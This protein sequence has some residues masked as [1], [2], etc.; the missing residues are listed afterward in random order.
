MQVTQ[1]GI[2]EVSHRH[3]TV[4]GWVSRHPDLLAALV[5][6]L[7]ALGLMA[8]YLVRGGV[9][10]WP[11]SGLG[12]DF[13][14]Y[15]WPHAYYARQS[16]RHDGTLPLWLRTSLGGEPIVG[17]PSVILFYPLHLLAVLLPLPLVP[18]FA[19]QTALHLWIAGIGGY[20][21]VHR[22]TGLRRPVAFVGALA[23]MLTPYLSSNAVGDVGITYALCWMPLCLAWAK[24]S[25]DE[26]RT[27][28]AILAGVALALQFVL[29]VHAFFLTA[30]VIGL[31]FAYWSAVL[32]A[33]WR[34]QRRWAEAARRGL[35]Q[36]GRLVLIAL[37]CSGVA[38]FELLPFASYLPYLS[39][40]ALT[41][42]ESNYF[43]LPPAMLATVMMPSAL[44]FPEWELYVGLLPLLLAPLAIL[45]P[46]RIEAGFWA[47]LVAFGV[48]FA[49]GTATPLFPLLFRY[50]PGF[51]WLRVPAR[52]WYPATVATIVLFCLSI[53]A[54]VGASARVR[55]RRGLH[56]YL[57]FGGWALITATVAGRW[58][59]RRAGELDWVL[60]WVAS[61]GLILALVGVWL[62]R[63]GRIR[64]SMLYALLVTALLVDLLP[65][66]A[67]YAAPRSEAELFRSPAIARASGGA[68]GRAEPP[69]R[70]YSV[71]GPVHHHVLARE[72]LETVN[73][74]NSF[75]FQPYIEY[76]KRASGCE[77]A[78]FANSVPPCLS[79]EVSAT[80]YLHAIPDPALL[81][82]FSVRYVITP[83]ALTGSEWTL[84][85]SIDGAYL[86]ENR[87]VMP[88]VYGVG[89]VEAV[90]DRAALWERIG[91]VDVAEVALVEGTDPVAGLPQEPFHVP[92]SVSNYG[93]NGM[94]VRVQMPGDGMLVVGNTWVPGWRAELDGVP[95]S[96]HRVNG[97]MQG[98]YLDAGAH[99][100]VLRFL[101]SS[102]FWGLAISALTLLVCVLALFK[103][104]APLPEL[105]ASATTV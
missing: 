77:L 3:G 75:Q 54:L 35:A 26:Q 79:N 69:Y 28:W 104:R 22:A 5:L 99:D 73:G 81:G 38:A 4:A 6:V 1:L 23:V 92:A 93:A 64:A 65:V 25:L 98:V 63:L 27:S 19:L 105:S 37:V 56:A 72:G 32:V 103:L 86:Y 47:F 16:L 12:T 60:G 7:V 41:L 84:R 96:V 97:A 87:A 76:I 50:A 102:L 68:D 11:R 40:E 74:L 48:L 101:P 89:R 58:I 78:G 57:L 83:V 15:R 82:L 10:P 29:H 91:Q 94:R 44:K 90:P 20:V 67:A 70:L 80:A 46:R 59:T 88:R 61:L 52:M 17:N 30:W 8:P 85:D 21:L 24:L 2:G 42:S 39:R 66:D 62:W 36:A 51:R 33:S 55:W 13:L 14:V 9:L 71:R 43:A 31:Y 95:V 18:A 49:L 45:H 34:V 53:E 100:V